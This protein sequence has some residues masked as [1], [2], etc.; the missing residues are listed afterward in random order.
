MIILCSGI[1]S[2]CFRFVRKKKKKEEEKKL[3]AALEWCRM[4]NIWLC[5]CNKNRKKKDERKIGWFCDD[6]FT[7]QKFSKRSN[8][9]GLLIW[10]NCYGGSVIINIICLT[11][12]KTRA[13]IFLN[14]I[15]LTYWGSNV[16]NFTKSIV[17]FA[18]TWWTC[19]KHRWWTMVSV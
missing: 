8:H 14:Y 11:D 12:M 6:Y 13:K 5:N 18:P 1:I 9:S 10:K 2:Y 7:K 15:T 19:R 3:S 17:Y 16:I 4:V